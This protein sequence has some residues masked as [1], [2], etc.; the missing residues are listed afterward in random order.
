MGRRKPA[1][2]DL[3]AA[4]MPQTPYH[5]ATSASVT[6]RSIPSRPEATLVHLGADR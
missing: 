1:H 2:V 6:D 5:V 4:I 3:P